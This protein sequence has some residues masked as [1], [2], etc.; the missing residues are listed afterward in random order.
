MIEVAKLKS[1]TVK[2][3]AAMAK[4]KGVPGWH[5]MRKDELI[6]ALAKCQKIEAAPNSPRLISTVR[7]RGYSVALTNTA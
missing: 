2:D 5:A 1:R 7:G 6:K 3:L 4:R